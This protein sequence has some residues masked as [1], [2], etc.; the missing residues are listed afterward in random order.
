[1]YD[2]GDMHKLQAR[3]IDRFMASIEISDSSR[4]RDT[5]RKEAQSARH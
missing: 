1:M 2:I 4:T 5:M 3:D